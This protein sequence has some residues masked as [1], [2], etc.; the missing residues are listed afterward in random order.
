M[1]AVRKRA[2]MAVS[3]DATVT[4]APYNSSEILEAVRDPKRYPSPLRPVGSGSATTP[5]R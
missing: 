2:A 5:T 4:I 1:S 3:T